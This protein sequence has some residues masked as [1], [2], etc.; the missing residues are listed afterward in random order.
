MRRKKALC[1]QY[2]L[3]CDGFPLVVFDDRDAVVKGGE[4]GTDLLTVAR[5]DFLTA[6]VR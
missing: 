5:R 1:E 6:R 4:F 2:S 3:V